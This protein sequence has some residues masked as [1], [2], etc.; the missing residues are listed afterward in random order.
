[1]INDEGA[2]TLM[3]DGSFRSINLIPWYAGLARRAACED[4]VA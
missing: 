1:L 4:A 3:T 2:K